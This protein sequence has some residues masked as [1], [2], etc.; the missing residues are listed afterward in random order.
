MK[1]QSKAY[2]AFQELAERIEVENKMEAG[3]DND[4]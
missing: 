2:G 1:R 4:K 3:L